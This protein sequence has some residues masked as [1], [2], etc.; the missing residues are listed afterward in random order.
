M[1][2]GPH[3][4]KDRRAKCA[5]GDAE[6]VAPKPRGSSSP[7]AQRKTASEEAT[8]CATTDLRA[9]LRANERSPEQ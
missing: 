8:T 5:Y 4:E 9:D 6:R 2:V 7:N 3:S 1:E